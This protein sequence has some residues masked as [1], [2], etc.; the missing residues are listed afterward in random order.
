M[1]FFH[2]PCDLRTGGR[3]PQEPF[4]EH[5]ARKFHWRDIS[6][7]AGGLRTSTPRAYG[8]WT[9]RPQHR[10]T[11]SFLSYGDAIL[12]YGFGCLCGPHQGATSLLVPKLFKMSACAGMTTAKMSSVLL[13]T[14]FVRCMNSPVEHDTDLAQYRVHVKIISTPTKSIPVPNTSR[15]STSHI[16]SGVVRARNK[17]QRGT[18]LVVRC[19]S[20]KPKV[21]TRHSGVSYACLLVPVVRHSPPRARTSALGKGRSVFCTRA[22]PIAV[23]IVF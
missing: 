11:S 20:D 12:S 5:A 15:F 21:V 4:E 2:L 18:W 3:S 7:L 19:F 17:M 16:L 9:P 8:P 6:A 10:L 22:R 23:H 14:I 13:T 1:D